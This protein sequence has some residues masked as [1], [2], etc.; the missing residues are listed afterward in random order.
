MKIKL[1]KLIN[2]S[3]PKEWKDTH[4]YNF[5]ADIEVDGQT[6][7][8]ANATAFGSKNADAFKAGGEMYGTERE[9]KGE[10]SFTVSIPKSGG[11]GGGYKGKSPDERRSIVRQVGF[12]GAME[13]HVSGVFTL[14]DIPKE[15]TLKEFID[16]SEAAIE[17]K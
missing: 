8:D 12:K 9:F 17:G 3:E 4:I 14:T 5:Q 15:L 10:V 1:I 16:I 13:G 11:G 2:E 7:T 6:K